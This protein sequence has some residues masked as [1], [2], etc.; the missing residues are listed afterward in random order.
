MTETKFLKTWSKPNCNEIQFVKGLCRKHYSEMRVKNNPLCTVEGC[1]NHQYAKGLCQLHYKRLAKTG[2]THTLERHEGCSVP[3]CKGK[4]RA[5]GLCSKH[6]MQLFH[7]TYINTKPECTVEGCNT[8]Q[9]SKGLCAKHYMR[10][11]RNNT[12]ELINGKVD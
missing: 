3:D 2:R 11:Y 4:H 6:Y 9:K 7:G 8:V 5:L 10:W 1:E 12:V